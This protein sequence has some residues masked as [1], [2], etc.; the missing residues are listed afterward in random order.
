MAVAAAEW[1]DLIER[2]YL[3]GFVTAGGAAVK[4]AIG[5]DSALE[6]LRRHLGELSARHEM[7]HV[8]IDAAAIRLHMIQDVFFAIARNLDWDAMAQHFVE[9]LFKRQ[10]YEWPRPG[11]AVPLDQVAEHNAVAATLLRRSL[12]Q[13]LTAQVMQDPEMSQDFCVAMTGLCLRRLEPE[14]T[15]PGITA[16]V[17]EW[18]RGELPRISALK[19]MFI[20]ARIT[21]HNGRAMLRSLCCWLRLCGRRGLCV[22]LDVRQLGRTGAAAG[23]GLRYS[24]AA[25]MDAFEV[26]RQLI[27]DAEHFAGLLLVVLAEDAL[28]GDDPKRSV[29]AYPAL[30]MR[31]WDDVRPHGLDN[32]LAP[33]VRLTEVTRDEP[34][35][36]IAS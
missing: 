30:K 21:R 28:I 10:G 20:A 11:D 24:P 3:R 22:A 31:I 8:Q 17:L 7:A 23:N 9:A 36:T 19:G 5:D 25:V 26:L 33:L 13:W 15:Q 14:D 34:S 1:L 4:F 29:G 12:Q 32:P 27:D 18:L 2:E 35:I 6:S 16:P